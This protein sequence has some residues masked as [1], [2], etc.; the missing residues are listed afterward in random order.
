MSD[1]LYRILEP[2]VEELKHADSEYIVLHQGEGILVS[3]DDYPVSGEV[4]Q[5]WV[6]AVGY[7]TPLREQS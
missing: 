6:M 7:Y 3:L 1:G 4:S 5:W 2:D